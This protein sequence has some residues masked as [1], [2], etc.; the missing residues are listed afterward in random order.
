ME[1]DTPLNTEEDKQARIRGMPCHLTALLGMIGIPL[2]NVLGPLIIWLVKKNTYP[3]VNEQGRESLNFQLSMTI[4]AIAAALLIFVKIG[5][6]LLLLVA[7]INF[8]LI[9][10]ASIRTFNGETYTYPLAIRL[11]KK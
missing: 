8:I 4:Y 7:G 9:I 5:M 10:I 11:I 1:E 2:G 3:F 6:P